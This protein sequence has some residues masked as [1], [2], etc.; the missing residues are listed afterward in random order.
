MTRQEDSRGFKTRNENGDSIKWQNIRGSK[1]KNRCRHTTRRQNSRGSRTRNRSVYKTRHM[2]GHNSGD[3]SMPRT[4]QQKRRV[5][6]M[7]GRKRSNNST[8]FCKVLFSLSHMF[9]LLLEHLFIKVYDYMTG[10]FY[11]GWLGNNSKLVTSIKCKNHSSR[12]PVA[13]M[14]EPK[15]W[16]VSFAMISVLK[17]SKSKVSIFQFWFKSKYHLL[18]IR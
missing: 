3:R 4:K 6:M 2:S 13:K 17:L 16:S 8:K 5:F 14:W 10:I 15:A 7:K 11:Y 18:G 1:T 9:V 12:Y